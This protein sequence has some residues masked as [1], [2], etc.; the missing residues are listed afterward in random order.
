[1]MTRRLCILLIRAFY[2][3]WDQ[4]VNSVYVST[5]IFLLSTIGLFMP[6]F[7]TGHNPCRFVPHT[8]VYPWMDNHIKAWSSGGKAVPNN[9]VSLCVN[10]LYPQT[11]LYR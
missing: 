11:M 9:I 2:Y 8:A 1:M 7:I 5:C 3:D 10:N 4:K 6:D